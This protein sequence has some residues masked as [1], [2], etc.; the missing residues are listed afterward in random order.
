MLRL[1]DPSNIANNVVT[2]TNATREVLPILSKKQQP[3]DGTAHVKENLTLYSNT[4]V[5]SGDFMVLDTRQAVMTKMANA[6]VPVSIEGRTAKG[7]YFLVEQLKA[8][9]IGHF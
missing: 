7:N 6:E 8:H 1:A 2:Y 3:G 5:K 4:A 9:N